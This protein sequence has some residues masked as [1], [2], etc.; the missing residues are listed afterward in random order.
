MLKKIILAFV[1][2]I[3]LGI[4]GAIAGY[5][6]V[7]STLPQIMKIEDYKPLLVSKVYDRNN[8]KIGEFFRER[9]ALVAY[10]D[11]PKDVIN[12]FLAAEDDQF[13]RHSGINFVAIM[14][15]TLANLR[16]GHTVQGGSTITQQ[17]AKTFFLSNERT[18][19][20]KVREA[21]LAIELERNLSKEDILFLYLNQ[22]FFGQN[23][24]GIG[25]A[26]ETY[27]RK[28][29]QKLTLAEIAI[30][31]GLPKA[32]SAYSPVRNPTRA[33]ERQVYVLNRMAEVG[34]ITKEQAEASA[35]EPVKVFLRETYEDKA[36]FFLE[37]VRLLL[38]KQLGEDKVLDGGL[39]IQTSLDIKKQ[40]AAQQAVEDHLRS[41]DKRQGFRGASEN[42]TDP[43]EVGEFLMKTRNRLIAEAVPERVIQP[44]GKFK[45][46]GPLNL[47]YSVKKNG[48]PFYLPLG[49]IA[50]AVVSKV[51]D[52]FGT[53][54][55][56]IAE[57][58]GIIDID[59]MSWARKP[60]P[61]K[62]FDLDQ[63]KK[64]SEALK[65][66]DI[67]Q[68]KVTD[69]RYSNPRLAKML[70]QLKKA[71]Q[72]APDYAKY[73]TLELEQE[74]IAQASLLSLDQQTQDVLAMVGGYDFAKSKF[75]RALQAARQTG[76]SFKSIVYAAALDRGYNPSTPIM[77]APLV[78][79]ETKEDEEGQED[80]KTWKPS[81]HSKS[82]GGDIIFR[83][84]LV[85]SLN[86]PTVRIIEDLG[87]PYSADYAR[88]LGIFS[89]LNMDF[90]LALGSSSVTLYEM[91]KSFSQFG[92]LGKKISP[93]IVRKVED[94]NGLKLMDVVSLDSW[95]ESELG[96]LQNTYEERRLKYLES[97]TPAEPI[98]EGEAPPAADEKSKKSIESH[99]FFQDADQ[100]I[101]PTTA[102]LITSLLKGVIEDRSG[103]GGRARALG[104]EV[105]GKTGTTNGYF[106]AWFIGYT[107]QIATGVWVGFDQ[108]KTLGKGEVGGRSALPIWVDYMKA[109][110]EELPQMTIPVPPGIVFANID[111][112]TGGLAS[113]NTKNII[114]QAF[115]EGT[116]PTGS[117]D[118]KE[119]DSDF[120]KTDLS[121]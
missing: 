76:S 38:S 111:A 47:E 26:A 60:N 23:A 27:Y 78:F 79:E 117:K 52:T 102:Y 98:A 44:D 17:V 68:V 53:V 35:K 41:L 57:I 46:Y 24:Y 64:P 73:V 42:V 114:R 107:A 37:T 2:L 61:E 93:V 1:V 7:K 67:I 116:E 29:V 112:E 49:K 54:H 12:A 62:R 56:R 9:R 32:P 28:P 72:A 18:I 91:T 43:K 4:G 81:N 51:D 87:V 15:A 77:D 31:A 63:I 95:F 80:V 5:S 115:L 71:G 3:V 59:S 113:A 20:R 94:S 110:H 50:P 120:Y 30:L 92:R 58:E 19:I 34:F 101:R 106:D 109:A 75:N 55:V 33:K 99:I 100:L 10:K 105:A 103:T 85:K 70:P 25:M 21:F 83:N 45:D 118:V 11:M 8:Q 108:E 36:P 89:P 40:M 16:A 74:P 48:L 82:F 14:R 90:T 69:S 96:T 66:G 121:E 65:M 88:R 119:E 86:V 22:I 97:L 84:A 13:F 39:R 6:Y 104:R